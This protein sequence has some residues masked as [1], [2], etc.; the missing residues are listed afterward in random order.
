MITLPYQSISTLAKCDG[1]LE[2]W[3]MACKD[4]WDQTIDFLD[5]WSMISQSP[6]KH[7]APK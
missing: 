3:E 7:E 4:S 6:N 5:K 1:N 2:E